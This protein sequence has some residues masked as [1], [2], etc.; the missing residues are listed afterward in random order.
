MNAPTLKPAPTGLDAAS[1]AR[2]DTARRIAR[3]VAGPA[4]VAVDRD[5]RFPRETIEA[6]KAA[7]M[8]SAHVPERFGGFGSGIAEL[9]LMCEALGQRCASSAMVFAMHQVQVACLVRHGSTPFFHDY[10]AEAVER[11]RLIASVTSE[12]G[13]GGSVRTSICPIDQAADG[14]CHVRK[15]GTVV[16]YGD[17]ADDLLITVRRNAES[18]A[19]DQAM[20]LARKSQCQMELLGTWDAMGMRGTCSPGYTIDAHF[21]AEQIVPAPFADINAHTMVPWA[22]ILWSSAWLGIATDAVTRARAF[23]RDTGKKLGNTP[24]TAP[25]L[26]QASATLQLMR[27]Q[28]REW[29]RRYDEMC[30]RPD[31]GAEELSSVACTIQLNH[32]KLMA[33]ELV[34]DICTQALRITGTTGYR[35][36]SPYSVTRH[37]RDAH[38]AALMIGNERIHAANGALHLVYRD[39]AI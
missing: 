22:H 4:A 32:L 8:L 5:G 37:L 25:R 2:V 21:D 11:Q 3:D 30:A 36:D 1:Q 16:S 28:V 7:R 27:V 24:P 33:S 29:A 23:V 34:A 18:V 19:H 12:Q 31:G 10:L 26:S 9:G 35:N 14:R 17:D 20:V 39:E 38:S 13:V 15:E 6:L